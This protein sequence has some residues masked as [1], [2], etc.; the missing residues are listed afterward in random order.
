MTS[1]TWSAKSWSFYTLMGYF[2][3]CPLFI[4]L[5]LFGF[6]TIV[7]ICRMQTGSIFFLD[8][9]QTVA[10]MNGVHGAT[11]LTWMWNYIDFASFTAWLFLA[12]AYCANALRFWHQG[13]FLNARQGYKWFFSSL[14]V[15]MLTL[16][17]SVTRTRSDNFTLLKCC[18]IWSSVDCQPGSPQPN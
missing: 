14:D 5:T 7:G 11:A 1:F 16:C 17:C 15:L 9:D 18:W 3:V 12:V 4:M 2:F 10:E 13:Q 8:P 6:R